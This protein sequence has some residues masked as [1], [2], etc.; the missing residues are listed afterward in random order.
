[1]KNRLLWE[2]LA[3]CDINVL[4]VFGEKDVK[5]K[6][7]VSRMYFEMSKSKKSEIYIIEMV[8]ILEV[9]YVVYLES[10]FYLIFVFRK[11]LIRVRKNFVEIEFS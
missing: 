6:K 10:F 3:D 4:F 5:F 1:M 7:I 11:F 2:E 8:E 9:G